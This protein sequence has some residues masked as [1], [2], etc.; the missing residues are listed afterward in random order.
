MNPI[1]LVVI[2][3]LSD[4]IIAAGGVVVGGNVAGSA[5]A[6]TSS[7]QIPPV[8]VWLAAGIWGAM[9]FAKEIKQNIQSAKEEHAASQEKKP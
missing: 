8:G 7:T 1:A 2:S 6:G 5:L 9:A 3:A 4:A